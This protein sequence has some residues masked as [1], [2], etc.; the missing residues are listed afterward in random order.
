[1]R[2]RPEYNIWK[3]IR[4][5]CFNKNNQAYDRYGGRGIK[6]C[7]RWK[8][9]FMNFFMDMGP[10]PSKKHSIDRMD[11][12]GNYSPKNCRWATRE[13]QANNK[14]GNI[15]I[16]YK[17][18]TKTLKQWSRYLSFNYH[19]AHQRLQ[20]G[21]EFE[22]IL[23]DSPEKRRMSHCKRGHALEDYNVIYS[24]H[25][26]KEERSCRACYNMNRRSM[27]KR[28][29]EELCLSTNIK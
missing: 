25:R 27:Y 3:G 11:N 13:E 20:A 2:T 22:E 12:D 16:T 8:A 4:N 17:G 6:L 5:R 28:K 7:L 21:W 15:N 23:K 9:S 29:K 18:E 24:Y 26:G 14:R 1:M 19:R 10:R